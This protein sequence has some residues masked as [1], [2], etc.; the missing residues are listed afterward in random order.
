MPLQARA[1]G[2][3]EID[4]NLAD[5]TSVFEVRSCI[6]SALGYDP[7]AVKLL[8]GDSTLDDSDGMAA[9]GLDSDGVL[10]VVVDT[11]PH[12]TVR[13]Y[14]AGFDSFGEGLYDFGPETKLG[15]DALPTTEDELRDILHAAFGVPP[16]EQRLSF[17]NPQ[18]QDRYKRFQ[19]QLPSLTVELQ[20]RHRFWFTAALPSG[21]EV[22]LWATRFTTA[23]Q[24]RDQLL[25]GPPRFNP[26]PPPNPMVADT[27]VI[28]L[29]GLQ[30]ADDAYLCDQGLGEGG[31]V[32]IVSLSPL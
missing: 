6:A 14:L 27:A 23:G 31:R 30:L 7:S 2:G 26:R 16:S 25:Q 1:L 15:V 9:I 17:V 11:R 13:V 21:E 22:N 19:S 3:E 32:E 28:V 24:V 4:V 18:N 20:T 10:N 8:K 29:N 5:C 12:L